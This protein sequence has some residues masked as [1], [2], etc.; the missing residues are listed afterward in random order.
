MVVR[1]DGGVV[2]WCVFVEC[3]IRVAFLRCAVDKELVARVMRSTY[4]KSLDTGFRVKLATVGI[5]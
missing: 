4:C 2:C 3:L 5:E 1:S